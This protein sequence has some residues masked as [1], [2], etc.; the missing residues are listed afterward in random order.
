MR[1]VKKVLLSI[2][3]VVCALAL[4]VVGVR[5]VNHWRYPEVS[6]ADP[7][8]LASY[9]LD[10]EGMTV[11]QVTGQGLAGFHLLPDEVTRDGVV[12]TFGGS[13]GGADYAR[14]HD[15]AGRGHALE[16][17]PLEFFGEV[18]ERIAQ[19]QARPGPLT[20]IG[21]SKGA[22]LA[23]LLAEHHPQID[24]VVLFAPS[25]YAF[26]GLGSG[27]PGTSSWSLGGEEVPYLSFEDASVLGAL[28]SQL[29]AWVFD[30]P[31]A[32][33]STYES[34]V[35]GSSEAERE[36]ARLD[37][38]S[39][40]GGLLVLAGGQDEMW[41]SDVAAEEIGRAVPEAEVHVFEEAGHVFSGPGHVAGLATGGTEEANEE[42][43]RRSTEILH[44]TL[45]AWHG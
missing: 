9:D 21:S 8:D 20:V 32:Y 39:V 18:A 6:G 15:L 34:V 24:N 13:E 22:E 23:L 10:Q 12:V 5:L 1:R 43:G 38:T 29:S 41:Q 2:L 17:V 31:T 45:D 30:H 26:Q 27:W 11:E 42:A 37:P 28:T 33:R 3:A 19:D 14:A 16:Q 7:R 25:M 4:V 44:E 36:A 40:D 35:E